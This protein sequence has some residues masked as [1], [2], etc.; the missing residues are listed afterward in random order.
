MSKA[1]ASD[2]SLPEEDEETQTEVIE[3]V[4]PPS[5]SL[6]RKGKEV[7]T[8]GPKKKSRPSIP[9]RSGGSLNIGGEET[10]QTTPRRSPRSAAPTSRPAAE[11]G[12]RASAAPASRPAAEPRARA[13]PC[14]VALSSLSPGPTTRSGQI[15]FF[16]QVP[17]PQDPEPPKHPSTDSSVSGARKMG[18]KLKKGSA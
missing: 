18:F 10:P 8:E 6:K 11:Q 9:L 1:F 16:E 2:P 12:A 14:H 13:S 4:P 5:T 17:A 3:D 7:K 15:L